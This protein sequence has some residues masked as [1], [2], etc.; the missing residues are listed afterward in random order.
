MLDRTTW[1]EFKSAGSPLIAKD[2]DSKKI[3]TL[4]NGREV[5]GFSAE[6]YDKIRNVTLMGFWVDEARE[7]KDFAGLWDVLMGRVLST[8]GKGIVT[9]SPNSY[10]D[11]HKIFIE[12]KKKDYGTIRFSTYANTSIDSSLIDDL[13]SKYDE[14]FAKQELYGELVVFE[15]AVYYTFNRHQNAG[16]LAFKLANY[17]PNQPICL[18]CDFNVN[19][20]AWVVAQISS[21]GSLKTINVIDEIYLKNAT[22]LEGC[23]EFKTRYPNHKAGIYLYGDATGKQRS[24]QS[25]VSNYQIIENELGRYGIKNLVPRSNPSERDRVNAVNGMI[26]NSKGFRR[27][28][29][30]PKCK[31][32]TRDL[33]QVS[34]KDGTTSIDK[35]RSLEL[36]HISD[37]FGY[38][39]ESEFSLIR[40][41]TTG[42][43]I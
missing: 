32:L 25:N 8:G 23:N 7:C 21:V 42:L 29:V 9:S 14:K 11:M 38:M 34:Y 4:K 12:E 13:A 41:I 30:N 6:N 15:G 39:V 10:D 3:I 1:R 43:R 35:T 24:T 18:C 17:N 19:P 28:Y 26:C 33:E 36:T 5:F 2:N 20:L 40:S 16:D 22:T 31:H 27:V 37:A